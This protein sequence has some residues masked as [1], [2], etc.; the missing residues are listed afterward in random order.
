MDKRLKEIVKRYEL[1]LVVMFGSAAR[2]QTNSESDTDIAVKSWHVIT[3]DIYLSLSRDLDRIYREVDLVD[4]RKAS[5]LLLANIAQEAKLIFEDTPLAF[6][7][8]KLFAYRSYWD[9]KEHRRIFKRS[10]RKAGAVRL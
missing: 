2:G 3:P 9:W 7:E 10:L 6:E 4:L 8:F 5:P 1:A